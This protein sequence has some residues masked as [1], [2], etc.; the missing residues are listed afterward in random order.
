[1]SRLLL[2]AFWWLVISAAISVA[3]SSF[4]FTKTTSWE[5]AK[6]NVTLTAHVT[7]TLTV[8]V[9]GSKRYRYNIQVYGSVIKKSGQPAVNGTYGV[10]ETSHSFTNNAGDR[11]T[12]PLSAVSSPGGTSWLG[13]YT[14]N[15]TAGVLYASTGSPEPYSRLVH[16]TV[17]YKSEQDNS[18]A[19]HFLTFTLAANEFGENPPAGPVQPSPESKR[20]PTQRVTNPFKFPVKY[21]W[22]DSVTGEVLSTLLLEPGETGFAGI[23]KTGTNPVQEVVTFPD[24]GIVNGTNTEGQPVLYGFAPGHSTPT[25]IIPDSDF[26][27]ESSAPAWSAPQVSTT[28]VPP[29]AGATMT[30]NPGGPTVPQL[31]QPKQGIV[32]GTAGNVQYSAAAGTGGATDV[33]VREGTGAIVKKLTDIETAVK[34]SGGGTGN[35]DITWTS[36][37]TGEVGTDPAAE[38]VT[39]VRVGDK[40]KML[41]E[42][43]APLFQGVPGSS[44]QIQASFEAFGGPRVW[45]FDAATYATPISWFRA[46]CSAVVHFMMFALV[47]RTGRNAAAG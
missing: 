12:T 39:D 11:T 2:P 46:L 14:N 34:N 8:P 32:G 20:G 15:I 30:P 45:L 24:G 41:P 10:M 19:G 26:V 9:A 29:V 7:E 1:M 17:T 37:G 43:P 3:H 23:S 33:S 42:P 28:P 22:K 25:K 47:A 18:D 31:A 44:S 27:P 4:G 13:Q 38:P 5:T 35:G 6:S 36:P 40:D 16:F 21:E